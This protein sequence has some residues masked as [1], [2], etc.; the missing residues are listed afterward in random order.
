MWNMWNMWN[1][2]N[3][4]NM[5]QFRGPCTSNVRK[6]Y[7]QFRFVICKWL[8]LGLPIDNSWLS[9]GLGATLQ[10]TFR[11]QCIQLRCFSSSQCL[12][13]SLLSP[14]CLFSSFSLTKW[15]PE[16]LKNLEESKNNQTY[17]NSAQ[18]NHTLNAPSYRIGLHGF[19]PI[20]VLSLNFFRLL[21][22]NLSS[23]HMKFEWFWY[24]QTCSNLSG[25]KVPDQNSVLLH[26]QLWLLDHCLRQIA[27]AY[28]DPKETAQTG[29]RQL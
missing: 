6:L 11:L 15:R 19:L 9:G 7:L 18:L 23:I 22:A 21:R 16:C 12:S 27:A 20:V 24:I 17:N 26:C 3:M 25:Q 29:M 1:M 2:R 5:W 10:C 4:W 28:L 13:L 14:G 8:L